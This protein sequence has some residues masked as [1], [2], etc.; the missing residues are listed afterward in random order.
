MSE[1]TMDKLPVSVCAMWPTPGESG[2]KSMYLRR[3]R[4]VV[5]SFPARWD[6]E[7]KDLESMPRDTERDFRT[8]RPTSPKSERMSSS[9]WRLDV[10]VSGPLTG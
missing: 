9:S 6:S 7:M 3:P 1:N 5:D 8:A 2:V 4:P 10:R